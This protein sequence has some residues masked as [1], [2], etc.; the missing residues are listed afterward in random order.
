MARF[1]KAKRLD[2]EL[3]L[4][5]LIEEQNL[6]HHLVATMLGVSEDWIQRSCKRLGLT[7]QRTGPRSGEQHPDW[8]GG[9]VIIKGYRFVYS[10]K[11]PSVRYGKYVAE[12]R[13]VA[14]KMLGRYLD[15]KEVVHHKDS[16]KLNN[17]PSNLETFANNAA[18]L[19]HELTGK[20]PLWTED[21]KKRI[22]AGVAKAVATH[23]KKALDARL[24]RQKSVRPT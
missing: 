7:T 22:A 15:P 24:L 9:V 2:L 20:Q 13:L 17:D 1:S 3:R 12:H 4:R 10:P 8:T 16:N 5:P 21:G 18:H 23:R 19:R 14:E 11:H 6:Q